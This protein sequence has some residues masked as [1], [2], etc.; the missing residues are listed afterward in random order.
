LTKISLLLISYLESKFEPKEF[1]MLESR[2]IEILERQ[3]LLKRDELSANDFAF[4]LSESMNRKDILFP[5]VRKSVFSLGVSQKPIDQ[6]EFETVVDLFSKEKISLECDVEK[7][8]SLSKELFYEGKIFCPI[9]NSTREGAY[10]NLS[11]ENATKILVSTRLDLRLMK[12]EEEERFSF[13]SSAY[14][15]AR[16]ETNL[17]KE[18]EEELSKDQILKQAIEIMDKKHGVRK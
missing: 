10:N 18:I 3:L 12:I 15:R 11:I 9:K 5:T 16:I 8:R 2:K 4:L 17:R 13:I 7:I 6:I 14:K 1:K